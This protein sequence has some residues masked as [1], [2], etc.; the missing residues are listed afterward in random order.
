MTMKTR[1]YL[2]TA[3]MCWYGLPVFSQGGLCPNTALAPVFKQDFGQGASS[4]STSSAAPGSTNYNFGNVGTD[5]NYIITPR[6]EN[7]NKNDWTRGGDHTGNTNGNMFL[8]NAGGGNSIFFQQTVS[9][10][11][12][13]SS[14]NFTAWIANVNTP[15]TQGICNPGLV[16]PKVIFNI[17]DPFG[18][19]LGTYTTGLLPLSPNSGPVNWQQYGFQFSLPSGTSSVILEMVDF[20]GGGAA[21]GNDVALDDIVFTAC[22]PQVTATLATAAAVCVGNTTT[23][24]SSLTNSPFSTPAYQWQKSTDNGNTW[25]NIGTPGTSNTSFSISNVTLAD[26]GMYRVLV[27][28]DVG[29]LSSASCITASNSITLTVNPLPVITAGSN[30]P[31]C[32]GKNLT[33]SSTVIAGNAPYTYSWTG[34]GT[35]V[36]SLASPVITGVSPGNAGS[37]QLSVSDANGCTATGS[38]NVGINPLPVLSLVNNTLAQ[39]SGTSTAI[40]FSSSIPG[41]LYYWIP[42]NLTGSTA[43]ASVNL[44][45]SSDNNINDLLTNTSGTPS[46]VRYIITALAPTTCGISDTTTVT[47]YAV[48]SV[49]AAGNDQILCNATG[50]GL[51]ATAPVIGTGSWSLLSGPSPVA[52]SDAALYNSSVSS[53]TPGN[54]QF[55]WSISNGAC[56]IKKDTVAVTIVPAINTTMAGTAQTVCAGQAVLIG[57]QPASGGTGSYQY[58]WEQSID[59]N[60]WTTIAGATGADY[61]FAAVSGMLFRRQTNSAP[62]AATSNTVTITVLPALSGNTISG[63]QQVCEGNFTQP[64]VGSVP[65]G[66]DGNYQFRWEQSTDNGN[67]W[68]IL[69]GATGRDLGPVQ[70]LSTSLLR[71]VVSTAICSGPQSIISNIVTVTARRAAIAGL[72]V[73]KNIGCAPFS[74]DSLMVQ[75]ADNPSVNLGYEWYANNV[76]I[77]TGIKFPGYVLQDDSTVIKLKV[78]SIYNCN[79]DSTS[80]VFSV[81]SVPA[82]SFVL[83]DTSGCGPLQVS[84][85]NNTPSSSSFQYYWDLGNGQTSSLLQP[86]YVVYP[87]SFSGLDT[88]YQITLKAFTGCD[89]AYFSRKLTVSRK[90]KPLLVATILNSCSPMNVRFNNV[91]TGNSAQFRLSFGDGSSDTLAANGL[92]QHMYY[93]GSNTSFIAT[94]SASNICGT[95]SISV[96]IPVNK[97]PLSVSLSLKDSVVCGAPYTATL[98]NFITGA[99]QI[100]WDWNVGSPL[101]TSTQTGNLAHNF[102]LPGTYL[103]KGSVKTS[104]SDT[105]VSRTLIVYPAVKARSA[106]TAQKNCVG[107]AIIFR[108]LSDPSLTFEWNYGDGTIYTPGDTI[109]SYSKAGDYYPSLKVRST[110]PQL[111]CY[112]SSI[113]KIS[114]TATQKADLKINDTLG[115]CTPFTATFRNESKP[116]VKTVWI[117]G[118]GTA[119]TG[120]SLQHVFTANGKYQVKMQAFSPAGCL[121]EDSAFVHI[122]APSVSLQYQGGVYCSPDSLVSFVANTNATDSIRW[123]FGDG[124]SLTSLPGKVSHRYLAAGKYLPSLQLLGAN[125][126]VVPVIPKDSVIID[127]IRIGFKLSALYD[128]G[129]TS[130]R[131]IDTSQSYFGIDKRVWFLNGNATATEKEYRYLFT[132]GGEHDATLQVQS[133]SGCVSTLDAKFTVAIYQYPQANI[134]SIAQACMN[135]LL[136][137]KS[138]VNSIDSVVIRSWNLGNGMSASDSIVN[139]A[140]YSEGKYTVKLTVATVN[141]C[142]D[143]AFKQL[144]IHAVPKINVSADQILCKG[145]SLELKAGGATN[146]VWKDQDNNILCT[147]CATTRVLPQKNTQYKV[148]GYSQFGCSEIAVTNVRVIQPFKLTA[149]LLDTLCAGETKKLFVSGASIYSWGNTPGLSNYAIASPSATPLTTTTYS[150][151]GKDAFNCFA[152]TARIRLVVGTPTPVN[153]GKDTVLLSGS[154]LQ[155]RAV[156]SLADIRK[157]RWEGGDFSCL[158]CPAP[159]AKVINDACITCTATNIYGCNS[160]DTVCIKT[161]CPTTEI[162]VPNAFTPDGDG[163]NDRL[164]VQGKGVKVIK[165]FRI[166]SRWGEL[167]FEK[168]NFMP[169][170]PSNGWDGKV[171]GKAATP[172]VFVYVCEVV[173]EKGAP[174]IFKGN[175]AILK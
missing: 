56:A 133:N 140:Y 149:K 146:Y 3:C 166:Y 26:G 17:K 53:L 39:C 136:E 141:N 50:T 75:A 92:L 104:C 68:T 114:I 102:S 112:D 62:C 164:F 18:A 79:A 155:L 148:I 110:H 2:L 69:N 73:V 153:V 52:F 44:V 152:D 43:G 111:S 6:V 156:S 168:T 29:S 32:V 72:T 126:C 49:A 84:F 109:H 129:K 87:S 81:F 171:R 95:D 150:V 61:G 22:T 94:L 1:Q 154:S 162:F 54:Y 160:I 100:S 161:F 74:I 173:C 27:G 145:D 97:S 19:V 67:T 135:N 83:S 80:G 107:D 28:P 175:V 138:E 45:G 31:V 127:D 132:Q 85:Q 71:R 12:S 66:G 25:N 144:T 15:N 147:S 159:V 64:I 37:Y 143:S 30:A 120:D 119:G 165:S 139:V 70:L 41:T 116:S 172:D 55:T 103:I 38:T 33:L 106:V 21:C 131:F 121:Y 47:V 34:P 57:A 46:T 151:I 82:P 113:S 40:Q 7:A 76:L 134:N 96:S 91:S 101:E 8:V 93:S 23:L 60:T 63:N 88:V 5:G 42:S 157:W 124:K 10:L 58:Q 128:C 125:N 90:V 169:G 65:V 35:F 20:H 105:V 13:G 137:L 16:Y 142:Y 122:N 24:N 78:T 174:S 170:D 86:G 99:T 89:T 59:G 117:W 108:N 77:G 167:V 130:F 98:N 11:C 158:N 4:S 123:D 9:G 51:N 163:I 115:R 36:S 48:P 14:F 118:D